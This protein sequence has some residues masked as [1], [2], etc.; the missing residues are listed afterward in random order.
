[1]KT[2]SLPRRINLWERLDP[3][4]PPPHSAAHEPHPH[5]PLF[6][7]V[8]PHQAILGFADREGIREAFKG[9]L[10]DWSRD[11]K[12]FLQVEYVMQGPQK[13]TVK[14]D[15]AVLHELRVPLGYWEAKDTADELDREIDRK[16]RKGYP[17]DNILFEES[18]TAV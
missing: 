5:Q 3:P 11:Q 13:N 17:Q 16:L 15:G 7:R 12:L 8:G 2:L 14:L 18:V 9:L 6:R 1:M 4:T 10:R